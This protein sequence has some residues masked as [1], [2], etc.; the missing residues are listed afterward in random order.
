VKARDGRGHPLTGF[1]AHFLCIGGKRGNEAKIGADWAGFIGDFEYFGVG[2]EGFNL[3]GMSILKVCHFGRTYVQCDQFAISL[4][5]KPSPDRDSLSTNR[6][7]FPL[8][9]FSLPMN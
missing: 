9:Q 6:M 8:E 2:N 4:L 5:S 1:V 3:E 7:T